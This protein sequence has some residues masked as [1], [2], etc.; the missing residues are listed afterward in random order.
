MTEESADGWVK[1]KLVYEEKSCGFKKKFK[2][3]QEQQDVCE[4][5]IN[6]DKICEGITSHFVVLGF[7]MPVV[8]AK[9]KFGWML[10]KLFREK[11]CMYVV[12][13]LHEMSK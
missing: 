4:L 5:S 3:Q 1:L 11:T 13:T 8:A 9:K 7:N 12:I 6:S 2:K 10:A